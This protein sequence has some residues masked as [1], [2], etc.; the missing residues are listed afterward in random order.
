MATS[1]VESRNESN[2]K[3]AKSWAAAQQT[4]EPFEGYWATGRRNKTRIIT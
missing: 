3:C 2:A 4:L 1:D